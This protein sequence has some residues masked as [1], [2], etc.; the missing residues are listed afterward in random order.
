MVFL[1]VEGKEASAAFTKVEDAAC[2][3]VATLDSR[4]GTGSRYTESIG[5]EEITGGMSLFRPPFL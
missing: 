3:I 4:K 5:W 2:V 1:T